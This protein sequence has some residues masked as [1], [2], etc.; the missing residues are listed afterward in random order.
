MTLGYLNLKKLQLKVILFILQKIVLYQV[1]N[2]VQ[3][4]A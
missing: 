4:P 2:F 1:A 3:N